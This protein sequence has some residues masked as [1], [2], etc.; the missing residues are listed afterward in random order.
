MSYYGLSKIEN[1]LVKYSGP[2]N[3]IDLEGKHAAIVIEEILNEVSSPHLLIV[4]SLGLVITIKSKDDF[5][6]THF[7]TPIDESVAAGILSF[8]AHKGKTVAMVEGYGAFE[9]VDKPSRA[10][11][12]KKWETITAAIVVILFLGSIAAIFAGYMKNRDEPTNKE[13]AKMYALGLNLEENVVALQDKSKHVRRAAARHLVQLLSLEVDE[14]RIMN[15]LIPALHDRDYQVRAEAVEGIGKI[16]DPRVFDLLVQAFRDRNDRVRADAVVGLAKTNDP[17]SI[18]FL[19]TAFDDRGGLVRRNAA[20][21][22]GKIKDPR[23]VD[24]LLAL[25]EDE[26]SSVRTSA[27]Y[28]LGKMK[29]NRAVEDLIGL[30]KDSHINVQEAAAVALG[31]IGDKRAVSPLIEALEENI[32][33]RDWAA[34]CALCK[35]GDEQ[36]VEPLVDRL[37]KGPFGSLDMD[38]AVVEAL[39]NIVGRQAVDSLIAIFIDINQN[40]IIRCAAAKA[41]RKNGDDHAV[42]V[43]ISRMNDKGEHPDVRFE[44]ALALG[45]IGG[46]QAA[47]ALSGAM[48]S[49]DAR[50]SLAA[51][52]ALADLGNHGETK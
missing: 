17:R 44:A 39:G 30:L 6:A 38:A 1:N 16:K 37:K 32:G 31:D 36:A 49:G 42:G 10:L 29:E 52:W 4:A 14:S 34:A 12:K 40:T 13:V 18:E 23:A 3:E 46:A 51:R 25:L 5:C 50:I 27:A 48:N 26:Y 19:I 47:K 22:F 11:S 24:P 2:I 28:T 33:D 21:A 45:Q 9:I 8:A 15:A 7:K 20:I 41:L 35:I 43:L